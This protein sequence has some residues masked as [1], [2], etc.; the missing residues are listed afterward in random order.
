MSGDTLSFS[1]HPRVLEDNRYVYVVRSRRARGIS[2]GINLNPD[3]ICNFDCIYCQVDRTT[4]PAIRDVDEAVLLAELEAILTRVRDGEL[5]A[6]P[7]FTGLPAPLR[8]IA[9]VSFAGDGEP[10]AYRR[11]LEVV[12]AVVAL[13]RRL[14]LETLPVSVLTNATL[15]DRP[16]VR[17]ALAILD[18]NRGEVWAKLDAGTAAYYKRICVPGTIRL[19]RILANLLDAARIRPL[20]IQSL[21][22]RVDGAP[23]PAEEIEAYCGRLN[24]LLAGGGRVCL[25]Q[26]YTV[27]RRPAADT[28]T[29]LEPGEVD[30]IAAAVRGRTALPVEAFYGSTDW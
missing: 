11:F 5:L 18:R 8:R 27:A 14:G 21:F 30:A 23:P 13:K 1:R 28:V 16:R 26:I 4:P 2:V 25:V 9:D 15:L 3:K 7:R 17:A 20:I 22:L 12:E 19:D 10:T 29:P 6:E 24:D